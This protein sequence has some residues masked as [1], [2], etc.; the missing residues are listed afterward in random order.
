LSH[1]QVI[2]NVIDEAILADKLGVDFFGVG[3]HH[4]ADFAIS[5]PEVVLAAIAGPPAGFG[6]VRQ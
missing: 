6:S 5:A 3:E 1:A 4:R 2:R